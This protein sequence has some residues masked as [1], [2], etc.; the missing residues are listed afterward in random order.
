MGSIFAPI[1]ET[2]SERNEREHNEGQ[3]D[4]SEAGVLGQVLHDNLS[5]LDSDA[6]NAGFDN[7]VQNQRK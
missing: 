5:A 1:F 3:K 6:Y 7:G 4:G 2:E